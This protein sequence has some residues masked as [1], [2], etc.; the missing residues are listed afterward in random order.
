MIRFEV[1]YPSYNG[2]V[3]ERVSYQYEPDARAFIEKLKTTGY[4]PTPIVLKKV[5]YLNV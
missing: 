2:D 3:M 4:N 5:E 1:H